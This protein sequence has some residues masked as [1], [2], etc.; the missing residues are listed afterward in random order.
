VSLHPAAPVATRLNRVA[1]WM[2]VGLVT[3]TAIVAVH[4]I[5]VSGGPV[6]VN[7]RDSVTYITSRAVPA[8]PTPQVSPAMTPPHLLREKKERQPG[9]GRQ[10]GLRSGVSSGLPSALPAGARLASR[11][12]SPA[13]RVIGNA[14]PYILPAGTVISATLVTEINSDLPGTVVAQVSRDVCDVRTGGSVLIPRGSKLI[15]RYENHLSVGQRRLMVTW[16][17]LVLPDAREMVLPELAA[18]DEHGAA[19]LSDVT[20]SHLGRVFGTS[21]LLSAIGAGAQLGQPTNGNALT[22]PSAGQV[23]AG[24]FGQQMSGTAMDLA[25]RG[26]DI[27]PTITA[28]AGLAFDILLAR[29]LVLPSTYDVQRR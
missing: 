20:D 23:A 9:L 3:V 21:V 12:A 2:V 13:L 26:A 19:G 24:A 8:F 27:P 14:S 5:A 6:A 18:I 11:R 4:Y 22:T 10:P 1:L 29:D 7:G 28:R 17:Q 25:R 16:T 15:G